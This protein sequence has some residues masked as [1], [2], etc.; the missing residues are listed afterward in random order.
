[1][2]W[3]FAAV[4]VAAGLLIGSDGG[5]QDYPSKPIK[6]VVPYPAGGGT[7]VLARLIAQ[8]LGERLGQPIVI[9]NRSGASGSIGTEFVVKSQPDGY[10]LLFN[11]ETLVIAPNVSKNLPY[12][13]V[14]DLAPIGL[15]ARSVI[16]IGAH[17]SVPATSLGELITL[18]KAQPSRLSYSSCGNATMMH[19]TG[20]ELK[21]L[22]GIEMTHVPYRG[23]G[24]AIQDAA[25][26]QVPVFVNA[27]TN[28]VNLE[29]RGRVRM[30]AI[31]S[32]RRSHLAPSV[33]TVA[34]SGFPGFDASP[35][36]ALFAP[37]G[38]PGEI[39][40]RLASDLNETVSSPKMRE[41]IRTMLFEPV[42]SSPQELAAVLRTELARWAEVAKKARI[43]SE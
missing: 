5:A 35:W 37:A 34:E 22:A 43:E 27:L 33:P 24:P 25:S 17:S 38:I 8:K 39:A 31:A 21:L 4:L 23:C 2:K 6:L 26:G 14:R 13:L 12:D 32:P 29:K 40:R 42:T 18:A 9:E 3:C 36:Q 1:M 41:R 20:E 15:I 11:N 10:T 30:L 7:D 28:V 19:F 16:I